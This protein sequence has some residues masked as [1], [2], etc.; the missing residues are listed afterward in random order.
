MADHLSLSTERRPSPGLSL[1]LPSNNPFRNRTSS[2]LP[3]PN[4]QN[5]ASSASRPMSSRNPF[6]T[7]FEAEFNR[8]AAR[9]DLIDID[10]SASMRES[11]KKPT[12]GT[13]TEDLFVCST[14]LQ[15]DG[16]PQ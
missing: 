14:R 16:C 2:P 15:P 9:N 7:T 11:P 1:N 5:R 3:S 4:D 6:L 10:M 13:A 8:Q 12:F